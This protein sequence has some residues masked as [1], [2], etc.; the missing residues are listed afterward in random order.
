[1]TRSRKCSRDDFDVGRGSDR[2]V[3]CLTSTSRPHCRFAA[4]ERH[5]FCFRRQTCRL[6]CSSVS[7]GLQR[8][9][10]GVSALGR[11]YGCPLHGFARSLEC[12]QK[13][14]GMPSVMGGNKVEGVEGD[15]KSACQTVASTRGEMLGVTYYLHRK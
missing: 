10:P 14:R 1:M 8:W 13:R 3:G 11:V 4:R 12:W 6:A 5:S 9:Y 15:R 2:H 7:D